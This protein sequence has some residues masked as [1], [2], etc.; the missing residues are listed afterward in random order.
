M[1]D[2]PRLGCTMSGDDLL[3]IGQA[4]R[5]AVGAHLLER[6]RTPDG[7]V[8]R[9]AQH[10]RGAIALRDYARR[11]QEC[12]SFFDITVSEDEEM[13]SVNVSGPSEAAP[14]LDLLYQLAEPA[15]SP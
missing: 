11:E 10:P 4:L 12:C 2:A 9:I 6:Q 13:L 15:A 8:I 1:R 5:M 14:L 3:G 7:L